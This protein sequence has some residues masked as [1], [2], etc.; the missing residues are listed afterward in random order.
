MNP[1]LAL[2]HTTLLVLTSASAQD[3]ALV[4]K[5][6]AI[7]HEQLI[8]ELAGLFWIAAELIIL[9][10]VI[11]ARRFLQE[12]PS[13]APFRWPIPLGKFLTT[14]FLLIA[15]FTLGRHFF[16]TP[17]PDAIKAG[18]TPESIRIAYL[19]RAHIHLFVWAVFITFWVV[20][21]SAIVYFGF[22]IY[23]I[24]AKMASAANIS[25]LPEQNPPSNH[26]PPRHF[27]V[28]FV[29]G[30]LVSAP[31]LAQVSSTSIN[32]LEAAILE[33]ATSRNLLYLYLRLAGVVW[34]G[35]EWIAA[36]VLIR[37]YRLC[38]LIF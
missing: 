24:L 5:A 15:I 3:T 14:L 21:E 17:L 20:L 28:F 25:L 34:V 7:F 4:D 27:L 9:Y 13:N 19:L 18:F 2:P 6:T 1:D 8:I 32:A 35:V 37:A 22:Q 12:L 36:V 23:Q 11:A 26:L 33:D 38:S 30:T 29:I 10:C 16:I 31:T